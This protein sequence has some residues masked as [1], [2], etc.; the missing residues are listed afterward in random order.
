MSQ[1]EGLFGSVVFVI[2]RSP[3]GL[4]L[5]IIAVLPVREQVTTGRRETEVTQSQAGVLRPQL[6]GET[7]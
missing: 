6:G 1:N 4:E 3:V 5:P 2:A 7:E